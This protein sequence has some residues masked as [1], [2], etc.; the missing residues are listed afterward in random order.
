[1]HNLVQR[2]HDCLGLDSFGDLVTGLENVA[3]VVCAHGDD[4]AD[5]N[6]IEAES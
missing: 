5:P 1:M 4:V 6:N 2:K 3:H